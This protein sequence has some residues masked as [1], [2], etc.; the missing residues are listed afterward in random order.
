MGHDGRPQPSQQRGG[1]TDWHDGAA[2]SFL[3]RTINAGGDPTVHGYET[4]DV[5]LGDG[6]VPPSAPVEAN[7]GRP[8][9]EVAAEFLS[10]KLW[11]EFAGTSPP[12]AVIDRMRVA[13]IDNDFE[14]VPWLTAMLTHSAF[15]A[16]DVNQGLVRS[17]V[18]FVVAALFATGRRSVAPALRS[19]RP[20]PTSTAQMRSNG[21]TSAGST[22]RRCAAISTAWPAT[23][24]GKP[25]AV[26]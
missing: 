13:A 23:F 9:R 6:T 12:A 2:K 18:E 26:G 16:S 11:I 19:Q 10:R 14:I 25:P 5:I 8:T 7:R 17:P 24:M 22:S 20:W 15:F 4:I 1:D 3:G 21:S